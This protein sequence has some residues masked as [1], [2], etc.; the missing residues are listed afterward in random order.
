MSEAP[1]RTS[2]AAHPVVPVVSVLAGTATIAVTVATVAPALAA[3]WWALVGLS[4]GYA[5][6]GSV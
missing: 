6:S 1:A 4:G 3:A 5:V 2:A